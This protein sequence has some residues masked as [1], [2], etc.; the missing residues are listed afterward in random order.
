[1]KVKITLL[2]ALLSLTTLAQ[3]SQLTPRAINQIDSLMNDAFSNGTFNGT[4]LVAKNDKILYNQAF[5]YT[6][7]SKTTK[8][9]TDYRFNIGSIT[10]EFSAVALMQLSEQGKLNVDDK[11]SKFLP[12]FPEWAKKVCIK[13]ILQFTSGLPNVIWKNIK[14]DN[15][16][17]EGLKNIQNL[18][19][20]PGTKYDYNNSNIFLRH[21][22]IERITGIPY[23]TYVE[24][25]IFKPAKMKTALLTPFQNK[26]QVAQGFN[27]KLQNGKAD[28]AISG[29]GYV[30]TTDLLKWSMALNSNKLISKTK[31]FELSKHYD[32]EEVQS[33]LGS[34]EYQNM[35]LQE[36]AHHGSAGSYEALLFSN[37]KQNYIIIL[38]DNN[39]NGKIHELT[40]DIKE[41]ISKQ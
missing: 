33:A 41:I 14:N 1:M 29:G 39:Y 4:I 22:I 7:G 34:T 37:L 31:L 9:T 11:V 32:Q 16:L 5:G 27:N 18:D 28:L 13:D 25:F 10:K 23:K 2:I 40:E 30:T 21:F 19:F 3:Q 6:N 36:H 35:E 20:E 24:K 26:K 15:N 12:E 8:L 38:L 17:F